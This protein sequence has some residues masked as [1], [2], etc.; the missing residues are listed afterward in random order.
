MIEDNN[1]DSVVIIDDDDVI[2]DDEGDLINNNISSSTTTAE[3]VVINASS[4]VVTPETSSG[5]VPVLTDQGEEEIEVEGAENQTEAGPEILPKSDDDSVLAVDTTPWKPI[6][7]IIF[8][9]IAPSNGSGIEPRVINS[10]ITADEI[11]S[12]ASSTEKTPSS[13]TVGAITSNSSTTEEVQL[14]EEEEEESTEF[15]LIQD[16]GNM[17][18]LVPEDRVRNTT[19]TTTTASSTT[20][21]TTTTTS[22]TTT[23]I[24]ETSVSS[25]TTP[26]PSVPISISNVT[27]TGECLKRKLPFCRGVLPYS[28]TVLPNWVG[29]K[30]EAERN[31]SVPYFE[32]IA[33]SEWY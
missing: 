20:E 9:V 23:T 32:I 21:S 19:S 24:K 17:A 5:F 13:T 15:S 14:L 1:D 27:S 7:K 29:D 33:E 4:V 26:V 22:A 16:L 12:V 18:L 25:S 2:I 10:E 6:P 31:L 11:Q 3:P 8:P 28:E 30:S